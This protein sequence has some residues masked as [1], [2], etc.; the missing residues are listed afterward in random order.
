MRTTIGA[1]LL[2]LMVIVIMWQSAGMYLARQTRLEM[3]AAKADIEAQIEQK[4]IE[5]ET[6][7]GPFR[8]LW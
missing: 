1:V 6:G 7:G 4:R 3:E 5:R 2:T 8:V